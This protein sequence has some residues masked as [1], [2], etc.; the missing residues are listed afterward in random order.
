MKDIEK[1]TSL[2]RLIDGNRRFYTD[3]SIVP[4]SNTKTIKENSLMQEPFV[5]IVGCS[6]SRVSPELLFNMNIGDIFSIRVVG[7][8]IG[9]SER[10]SIEYG[11]KHLN[12]PLVIVLGHKGCGACIS[13]LDESTNSN[14]LNSILKSIIDVKNRIVDKNPDLDRES[15]ISRVTEEN[16]WNSIKNL[17]SSSS[18]I[19]DRI[20]RCELMVIGAI[21]DIETGIVDF[22]GPHPREKI[23]L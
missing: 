4:K 15:L 9:Q 8:V 6:D 19:R 21:Y 17:I 12:T 5:T 23:L 13:A 1:N 18:S 16:V 22:L 3:N 14:E 11:V 2:N 7:N 20:K 10:G